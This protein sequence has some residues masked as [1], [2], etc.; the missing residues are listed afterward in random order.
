[1]SIL[2]PLKDR[3]GRIKSNLTS[4]DAQP[5][6]RASL[7]II[8]FL[9]IFILTSIFDGLNRHTKQLPTPDEYIT[10]SCQEIVLNRSWNPTSRVQNLS[11]I[12][13]AH[14]NNYY[15]VEVRKVERH[16]VCAPYQ[17]LLD[18]IKATG[19]LSGFSEDRARFV[20]E[21]APCSNRSAR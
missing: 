9:D 1:M 20:R 18:R 17:D 3:F 12:V 10:Y 13:L 19:T 4:L 5:L 2:G 15:Q 21:S 14:Y 11:D 16:A 7:V 6:S 8:L